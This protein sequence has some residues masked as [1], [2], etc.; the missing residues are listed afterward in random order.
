MLSSNTVKD[1]LERQR[2]AV[3]CG[4]DFS[5]YNVVLMRQVLIEEFD[6]FRQC[7][8]NVFQSSCEYVDFITFSVYLKSYAVIFCIA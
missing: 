4:N 7:I 1:I 2:L 5:F 8:G 3:A 6:D